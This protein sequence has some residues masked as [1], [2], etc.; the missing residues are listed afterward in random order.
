MSF[1]VEKC[2]PFLR[3]SASVLCNLLTKLFP[4]FNF[5][6]WLP[7]FFTGFVLAYMA[8]MCVSHLSSC[9]HH[10]FTFYTHRLLHISETQFVQCWAG[11]RRDAVCYMHPATKVCTAYVY[12]V[13]ERIVYCVVGSVVLLG[14]NCYLTYYEANTIGPYT[15]GIKAICTASQRIA[16]SCFVSPVQVCFY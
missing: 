7:I 5:P 13:C 6:Y 16:Y 4:L 2:I 8:I 1:I 9:T 12:S 3:L 11:Q 14:M 10:P 15:C